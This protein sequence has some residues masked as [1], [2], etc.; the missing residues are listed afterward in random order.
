MAIESLKD[1]LI[2]ELQDLYGAEQQIVRALPGLVEK[3]SDAGLRRALEEHLER[4]KGH[5]E[6][7]EQT[8]RG[9]GQKP[10][11]KT[12]K[13]IAGI[14]EEG[15]EVAGKPMPAPVKDAALIA[16]A[17]KVEH[18]EMAA[19]G[20]VRAFAQHLKDLDTAQRLQATLDEE[21][22]ADRTLTQLAEF[23]VNLH[24]AGEVAAVQS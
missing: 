15:A 2:E 13:G 14:L 17:Q 16:A 19:Y 20:S 11:A 3:A 18:Y 1:L 4:T 10:A 8:L 6:R 7:L 24:A 22:D 21:G 9:L 23:S 5:V 12:C